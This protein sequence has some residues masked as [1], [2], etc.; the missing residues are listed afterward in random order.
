MESDCGS[1]ASL[2]VIP[3][4]GEEGIRYQAIAETYKSLRLRF[5]FLSPDDLREKALDIVKEKNEKTK[6]SQTV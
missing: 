4:G 1:W 2:L 6:I 3:G 5:K